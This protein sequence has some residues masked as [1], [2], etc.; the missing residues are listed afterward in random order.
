MRN[1]S[2]CSELKMYYNSERQAFDHE[3]QKQYTILVTIQ[4]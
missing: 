1:R 4:T 3:T 2:F